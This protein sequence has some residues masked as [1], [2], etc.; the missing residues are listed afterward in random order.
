MARFE[1]NVLAADAVDWLF[2]DHIIVIAH[3]FIQR[4]PVIIP[5]I[6]GEWM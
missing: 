4:I 5:E 1:L 6:S 3:M 2:W